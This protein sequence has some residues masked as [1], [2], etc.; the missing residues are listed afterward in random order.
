MVHEKHLLESLQSYQYLN[1]LKLPEKII[2]L[3][4]DEKIYP[5][6]NKKL[7]IFDMDETLIH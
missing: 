1:D 2:Q 7:L 3:K 5:I 4:D 6:E